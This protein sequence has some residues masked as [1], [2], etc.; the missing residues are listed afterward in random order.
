METKNYLDKNGVKRVVSNM[1]LDINTKIGEVKTNIREHDLSPISHTDIRQNLSDH[2]SSSFSHVNIRAEI[3]DIRVLAEGRLSGKTF[4]DVAEMEVWLSNPS[5][6]NNLPFGFTFLIIDPEEPDYRWDGE[7]A[8]I[9]KSGDVSLS[10]YYTRLQEDIW[11]S[12]H[13]STLATPISPAHIFDAPTDGNDYIRKDGEWKQNPASKAKPV[14]GDNLY[15][16]SSTSND[17]T[18][19]TLTDSVKDLLER[20]DSQVYTKDEVENR[21]VEEIRGVFVGNEDQEFYSITKSNIAAGKEIVIPKSYD[22][23][24]KSVVLGVQ[25]FIEGETKTEVARVY[26][27]ANKGSFEYNQY[28][29]YDDGL[30]LIREK[31]IQMTHIGDIGSNGLYSAVIDLTEWEEISIV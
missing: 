23:Y 14:V 24:Y 2:D 10:D 13:S 3:D 30:G 21:I 15:T 4:N 6:T 11:R 25:E 26:N 29:T 16:E 22:P 17:V 5:N 19:V 31:T 9:N 18:T 8:I 1:A 20:S 7:R 12:N 27:N 28:V